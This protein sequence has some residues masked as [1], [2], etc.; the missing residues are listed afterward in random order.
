MLFTILSSFATFSISD[1]CEC[2]GSLG[3]ESKKGTCEIVAI[4]TPFEGTCCLKGGCPFLSGCHECG[5]QSLKDCDRCTAGSAC[6][7]GWAG[8]NCN[9]SATIAPDTAVPAMQLSAVPTPV[10]FTSTPPTQPPITLAPDT[11][12]PVTAAPNTAMPPT[13]APDT[14]PPTTSAPD[15]AA[16]STFAPAT[17]APNTRPPTTTAPSTPA[18]ATYTAPYYFCT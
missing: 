6:F 16:P 7:T 1:E 14:K 15:T 4:T 3:W 11:P 8:P 2:L 17:Q 18:P 13:S 9:I 5:H 10:P 12:S